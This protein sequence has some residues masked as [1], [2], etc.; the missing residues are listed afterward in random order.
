M[1]LGRSDASPLPGGYP[2]PSFPSTIR[3]DDQGRELTRTNST[4]ALMAASHGAVL[5][6][7]RSVATEMHQSHPNF[8]ALL[9]SFHSPIFSP[10]SLCSI[11]L[12]S[13][14]IQFLQTSLPCQ[15]WAR[16]FPW[17]GLVRAQSQPLPLKTHQE[18]LSQQLWHSPS[19]SDTP[20]SPK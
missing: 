12:P 11:T 3:A 2:K 13:S 19:P 18:E 6:K 14:H 9:L 16:S 1:P 20:K 5:P 15:V 10:C 17:H 7:S 4:Q 8:L